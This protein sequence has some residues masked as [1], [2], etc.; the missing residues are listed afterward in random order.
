MMTSRSAVG[1]GVF[2]YLF[3]L[4]P[5]AVGQSPF[6]LPNSK[7]ALVID[8]R[9]NDAFWQNALAVTLVPSE[10]GVPARMGGE[11]RLVVAGELSVHPGAARRAGRQGAGALDRAQSSM[12]A[13]FPGIAAR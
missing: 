2:L 10:A 4:D 8:G 13:G 3:L 9:D 11:S 6:R 5:I 12:G 7:A 1:Y